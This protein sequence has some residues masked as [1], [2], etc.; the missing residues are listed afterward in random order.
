[1]L[2]RLAQAV[3]DAAFPLRCFDCGRLYRHGAY[4]DC[5]DAESDRDD[6]FKRLVS[7][8]LCA[9]CAFVRWITPPLCP[10]CGRPFETG[11]GMDHPCGDCRRGRFSFD[12]A[13]AVG[14]YDNCLPLLVSLFKYRQMVNLAAPLGRLMWGALA[15]SRGIDAFD[16]ICPVPLHWHR[17]RRRGFNQAELLLGTWPALARSEG[18][19]FDPG[20]IVTTA[21][22]RNRHTPSQTELGPLQ[23]RQ[24]LRGAFSVTH[25]HRFRGCRILLVDDV[26]TT[27]ATANACARALKDAGAAA[28]HV[29]TLARAV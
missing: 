24:N 3:R 11:N 10:G 25:D 23:R 29:L 28:V 22:V 18:R 1:M 7:D 26:L 21:L 15:R 13:T 16:C 8:V 27:G 12:G 19:D 5:G 6:R 2:S 4:D 14:I 17:K 9:R 20:K